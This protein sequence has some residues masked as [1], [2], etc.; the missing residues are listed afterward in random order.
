MFPQ[1]QMVPLY[2]DVTDGIP[3]SPFIVKVTP[4]LCSLTAISYP[5]IRQP[6][7]NRNI[8]LQAASTSVVNFDPMSSF[9]TGR[10]P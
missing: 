5:S 2:H 6:D 7:I 8:I 9:Q 10:G 3:P 1:G 4:T